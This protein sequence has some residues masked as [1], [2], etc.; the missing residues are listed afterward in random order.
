MYR[1]TFGL[2]IDVGPAVLPR[3]C[4]LYCAFVHART[5]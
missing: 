3:L 2:V 1:V 5:F 4:C